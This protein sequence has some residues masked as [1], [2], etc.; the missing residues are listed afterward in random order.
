M[1]RRSRPRR[2]A[3][4]SLVS[5]SYARAPEVCPAVRGNAH[6]PAVPYAVRVA[7]APRRASTVRGTPAYPCS[8]RLKRHN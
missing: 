6:D 4:R 5:R 1:T 2:S 7:S 3:R 8:V